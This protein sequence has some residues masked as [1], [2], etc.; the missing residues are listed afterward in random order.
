[1][2]IGILSDT[3]GAVTRTQRAV[4]LLI[5][6][7]AEVLIHCGDLNT[8]E[9]VAACSV[10]PFYFVFGNH[11]CDV[12]PHLLSAAE[13]YN[14]SCLKW[15]GEITIEEKRIAVCHGHLTMDIK[16]LLEAEPHYLLSGH[17][18]MASNTHHGKTRRIN[19]GA[20]FRASRFTVAVLDLGTDNLSFITV[21]D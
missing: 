15:G 13:E 1:M 2:R 12:V 4:D 14:V 17:S 5:A 19:P 21:A 18:H 10:R 16:P 11:D 7:G 8:P 9:I 6:E 3:H 20:L